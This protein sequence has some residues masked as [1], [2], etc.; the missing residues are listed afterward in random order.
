LHRHSGLLAPA[1]L[2]FAVLSGLAGAGIIFWFLA[3][4]LMPHER[5]LTAEETDMVGVVG[6]LTGALGAGATGE[7]LYSQLGARRS[8]A[9][10]SED[11][12]SIDR[13]AEVVVLRYEHGI[14]YVR[15]WDELNM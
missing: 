1:V 11:G 14:A 8:A 4:V 6:H 9:A 10:R 5:E 7:I 2:F 15:K 12:T 3:S 13:G